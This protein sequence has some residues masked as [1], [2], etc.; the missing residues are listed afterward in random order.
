MKTDEDA[1]KL[2]QPVFETLTDVEDFVSSD[3]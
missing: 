2:Y 3:R 1:V